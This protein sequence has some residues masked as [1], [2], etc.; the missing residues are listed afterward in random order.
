MIFVKESPLEN[1]REKIERVKK[2]L[3][4]I[5]VPNPKK[6]QENCEKFLILRQEIQDLIIQLKNLKVPIEPELVRLQ[7]IDSIVKSNIR[8]LN[9]GL[10]N[11]SL[12]SKASSYPEEFWWWH[13][14]E[15]VERGKKIRLKKSFT[16]AGIIGTIIIVLVLFF[17]FYKTPEEEL[18]NA[19]SKIDK[20]VE[21]KKYD[22]AEKEA[23][24][25]IEKF[26]NRVEP[27]IKLGI[28]QEIKGSSN[29]FKTFE[30]A[31]KL[32]KSED[33]FYLQRATEYLRGGKLE[34]AEKDIN[35]ILKKNNEHPQALY[36]LGSIYEE[37]GK[38]Y[39]AI[40]VYKKIDSLGDKV[41]PQ[42][43]AMSKI[44]LSLLLQ[45]IPTAIP[46]K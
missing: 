23:I 25:L 36:V 27:W 35:E 9:K 3:G 16:L 14:P 29:A 2:L 45:K 6:L 4:D 1:L 31:K 30:K 37:Q 42:I 26:P 10:K 13:I 22:V 20:L 41:D 28:V 7:E 21:E 18:L 46:Q 5:I 12:L 34:K 44:R 19:T 33:E 15:I 32:C 11:S 24:Q 43:V 40:A 17:T 38:F 8:I 39:D